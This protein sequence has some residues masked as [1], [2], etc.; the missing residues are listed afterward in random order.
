MTES[1]DT[2]PRHPVLLVNSRSGGGKAQRYDLVAQCRARGIEPVVMKE[3]DELASLA[4]GAVS[5]GVDVIGMAGGDGSQAIVA[6]VAARHDIPYVCIPAGTRNHFALDIGV[7]RDDVVGALD[8]FHHGSERRIDLAQVN[9]RVFVNN[10]SMGLYG[11]IVKSPEYRDAKL[12]T[13]L[14]MLPEFVGPGSHPVD[15]RFRDPDGAVLASPDILMVSNNRYE[16]DPRTSPQTRGDMNRG[17]LGMVVVPHGPQL[18]RWREWT[19]PVFEVD[20]NTAVDVGLDGEA[21]SLDPP[22]HFESWPSALR[23]RCPVR[24]HSP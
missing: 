22:L 4:A 5:S 24:P 20:S 21:V 6:A 7:D 10:A 3:G 8:A 2:G 11:A 23:I 16:L 1:A 14:E 12:R 19:A 9:G 15:L 17:V 18:Q 13:V